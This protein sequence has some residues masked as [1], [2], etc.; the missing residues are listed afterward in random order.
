MLTREAKPKFQAIELDI[1]HCVKMFMSDEIPVSDE[2]PVF[3]EQIDD[4]SSIKYSYFK[5]DK[6]NKKREIIEIS[7]FNKLLYLRKLS[8]G[9]LFNQSLVGLRP[10]QN[11]QIIEIN[12]N[13]FN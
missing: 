9:L 4:S 3:D 5:F 10:L 12:S 7:A 1:D 2:K 11:L 8:V 13:Y 6:I